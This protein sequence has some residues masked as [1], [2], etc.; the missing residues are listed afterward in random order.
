[1]LK[2]SLLTVA[3][4]TPAIVGSGSAIVSASST[5]SFSLTGLFAVEGLGSAPEAG[6][7]VVAAIAFR[8]GTNRNITVTTSGYTEASDLNAPAANSCQLGIW[9]K[10]LTSAETSIAFDIGAAVDSFF[11]VQVWRNTSSTQPDATTTTLTG[12]N[13]APNA[14]AITTA[15]RNAVVIAVM[16]CAAGVSNP[17][18][19]NPIISAPFEN[20]AS[21]KTDD[22][23]GILIASTYARSPGSVDPPAPTGFPSNLNNGICAATL[24]IRPRN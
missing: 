16:A 12:S 14:P 9:Y 8:D 13:Q 11:A 6:D 17:Y 19:A 7:L 18:T 24:A 5:P 1:M 2:R 3:N 21:A 4:E 15:T 22:T 10:R 23:C 20:Q